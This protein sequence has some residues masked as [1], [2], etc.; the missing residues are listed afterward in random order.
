[1]KQLYIRFFERDGMWQFQLCAGNG[2]AIM[3]SEKY[4]TK[5][6][7]RKAIAIVVNRPI[8]RELKE[9]KFNKEDI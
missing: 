4:I 5:A 8:S 7:M 3:T 6:G 2:E 9:G 1:M